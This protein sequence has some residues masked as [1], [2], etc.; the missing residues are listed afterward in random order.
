MTASAR[1]APRAVPDGQLRL[2]TKVARM[3]HE[4][5]IRQVE[6]AETLHLS[7][8]R[9]SR[10]LKRAAELG[11]VR[12]VVVVAQ[13]VH[14]ELEE[15]LEERYGL[16]EALVVDVEG[17]EAD[18]LA[19]LGSAGATYL[20]AT[21]TGGERIGI[22]PWSQTLLSIVERMRPLRLAGADNVVQLIGGIGQHSAQAQANRLLGD[23]AGLLGANATFVAAPGLVANAAVR[24][25]LFGEPGMR[26]IRDQWAALT[27]CLVGI[28][29]LPPSE[30]LRA[31]GNAVDPQDQARLTAAGAVGDV[32]HRFFDASGA[33]VVT[34]LDD[35]VVGIDADTLRAV[36]RRIGIAGGPAKRD[37]VRA[38]VVGGW[39]NVL[40]TDIGTAH[41]LLDPAP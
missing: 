12:T 20:E 14:T 5:G 7:Q 26:A 2:I 40:V 39:V 36:P 3:Y 9:V 8:A 10:L 25:S 18:I 33:P 32:C 21:L 15:A 6:I 13:G 31:S 22:A 28:G 30:F 38:A 16:A 17:S 1:P 11:I 29:R 23:L 37:A 27:M 19:G 24:D 41:A 34:E 35:R 4:R